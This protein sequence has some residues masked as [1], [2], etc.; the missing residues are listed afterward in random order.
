MIADKRGDATTA[1]TYYEKCIRIN[2]EMLP[3]YNELSYLLYRLGEYEASIA[4]N[5]KAIAYNAN[6]PDPYKNIA[7]TYA[8]MNQ[9]EKGQ[10]YLQ[11]LENMK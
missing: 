7:Q 5:E 10:A 1:I 9:P 4:V 8:A 6:W 2:P 11:R 3:P